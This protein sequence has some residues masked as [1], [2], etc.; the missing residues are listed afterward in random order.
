ML[1]PVVAAALMP[2]T[3][4]TAGQDRQA[5]RALPVVQAT[6]ATQAGPSL[7]GFG[8]FVWAPPPEGG[9]TVTLPTPAGTMKRKV[10][11]GTT[12]IIVDSELDPEFVIAPKPGAGECTM[13]R[14]PKPMCGPEKKK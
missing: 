12:V 4:D 2:F 14:V 6:P 10:V 5:A 1:A 3:P 13:K 9:T 8:V 11:C 7:G